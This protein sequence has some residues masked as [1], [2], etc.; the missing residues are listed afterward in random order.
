M[1]NGFGPMMMLLMAAVG[2]ALL[3]LLVAG[4]VWLVRALTWQDRASP[5]PSSPAQTDLDRR[6]ARGEIDRDQYLRQ[7]A[8]LERTRS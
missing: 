3:G 5:G 6:Y 2:I 4:F 7:R 1:M 8:D